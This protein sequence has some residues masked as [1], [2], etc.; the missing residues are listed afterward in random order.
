MKKAETLVTVVTSSGD[1][2]NGSIQNEEDKHFQDNANF[3]R[4]ISILI[5]T[6]EDLVCITRAFLSDQQNLNQQGNPLGRLVLLLTM[7]TLP[8]FSFSRLRTLEPECLVSYDN[9]SR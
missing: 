5:I 3:A 9:C 4:N 7:L 1:E 8:M 6:L 2:W